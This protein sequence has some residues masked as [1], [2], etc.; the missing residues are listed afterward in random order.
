MVELRREYRQRLSALED[1]V[2][3]MGNQVLAMLEDATVAL[4]TCDLE[5][6][7]AVVRADDRLDEAY[8]ELQEG[9]LT[10]IALQAPVASELRLLAAFLHAN[11]HLER[12]GD[13]CVNVSR[14]VER[15]CNLAGDD[16]LTSELLEMGAHA[17]KVIVRS[18][19]S[20]SRRDLDL[21]ASLPGLD[22]PIDQL[23]RGLF[24]RLVRLAAEDDGRLDWAM[25]MVLVARYFERMADHA[26]DIGEQIHYAMTGEMIELSSNSPA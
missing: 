9:V 17:R 14:S 1:Q 12:M 3:G 21:V 10:T 6:A 8:E 19:E 25:H 5:R 2:L 4:A 15:V 7:D 13:L 24:T 11:I 18:M 26:V 23:N 20:V 16:T 22:E